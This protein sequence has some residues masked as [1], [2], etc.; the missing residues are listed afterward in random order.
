[1]KSWI[2]IYS[3]WCVPRL[4]SLFTAT[5]FPKSYKAPDGVALGAWIYGIRTKY[6]SSDGKSL[7]QSQKERLEAVRV[8]LSYEFAFEKK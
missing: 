5:V 4:P 3:A 2:S 6:R 1:M 8:D 7:T